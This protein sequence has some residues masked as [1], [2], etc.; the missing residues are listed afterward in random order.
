MGWIM[1]GNALSN[2]ASNQRFDARI[3]GETKE[4]IETAARL[5]GRSMSDFVISS[6]HEAARKIISENAIWTL[7]RAQ[8]RR[9]AEA[10]LDDGQPG[11]KLTEAAARYR[12]VT[13][14]KNR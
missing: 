5:T 13:S 2:S 10:M 8:S 14:R 11:Q 7:N 1:A 9:F 4:I 3:S 6:A 12:K